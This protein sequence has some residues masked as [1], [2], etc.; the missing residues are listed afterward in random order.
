MTV[1]SRDSLVEV[2]RNSDD[3]DF[4]LAIREVVVLKYCV[5]CLR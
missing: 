2:F 1:L 3:F 4:A 5:L